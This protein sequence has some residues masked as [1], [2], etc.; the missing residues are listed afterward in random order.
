[1]RSIMVTFGHD[2]SKK[3]PLYFRKFDLFIKLQFWGAKILPMEPCGKGSSQ[4][5]IFTFD[6]IFK[7]SVNRSRSFLL[8]I[9][10][11]GF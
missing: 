1:M 8:N 5:L 2:I 11:F 3:P 9:V 10:I 6:L 7:V 4:V